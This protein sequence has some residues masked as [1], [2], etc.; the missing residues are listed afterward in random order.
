MCGYK[1]WEG[2]E[3]PNEA[4]QGTYILLC[5]RVCTYTK[6]RTT[7]ATLM[8]GGDPR[9]P[10]AEATPFVHL[11]LGRDLHTEY[12]VSVHLATQ[13][14]THHSLT[15]APGSSQPQSHRD[16]IDGLYGAG[17]PRPINPSNA[18]NGPR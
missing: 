10:T 6:K 2:E 7:F 12:S 16:A 4:Q 9:L 8:G 1:W 3:K 14:G 11:A 15:L 18:S 5:I 17:H 13:L